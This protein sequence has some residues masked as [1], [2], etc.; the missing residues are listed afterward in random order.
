M[1]RL[2]AVILIAAIAGTLFLALMPAPARLTP[3]HADN[4]VP[5]SQK[6]PALRCLMHGGCRWMLTSRPVLVDWVG[7]VAI[8]VPLGFACALAA[9]PNR[10]QPRPGWWARVLALGVLFSVGIEAA[11]LL[12]PG[13]VTDVDDV[14]LNGAGFLIGVVLAQAFVAAVQWRWPRPI[15]QKDT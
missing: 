6:L 10:R 13:R 14:I 7:N 2:A 4:F 11:Q 3:G 5:F 1:R 12:V 9:W 8:F 15:P